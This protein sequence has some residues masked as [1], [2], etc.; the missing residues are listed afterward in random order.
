M[1]FILSLSFPTLSLSLSPPLPLLLLFSLSV[2]SLSFCV[3]RAERECFGGQKA[4][5]ISTIK[6]KL[7]IHIPQSLN[8][9]QFNTKNTD[10]IQLSS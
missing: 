1:Y 2:L 5:V 9:I 8:R 7:K 3:L 4:A 6:I 10:Y